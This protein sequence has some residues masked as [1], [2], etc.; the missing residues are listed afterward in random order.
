MERLKRA[1]NRTVGTKQTTKAVERGQAQVV[2]V[3]ADAEPHVTRHLV[4]L[5]RQKGVEIVEVES[6]AVL[7]RACGV[8]VGTASAGIL[9][10]S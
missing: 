8:E 1:A 3:A 7:G 4:A 10:E 5:C 2:F 6:M 9:V